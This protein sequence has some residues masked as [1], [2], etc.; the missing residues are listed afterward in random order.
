MVGIHDFFI[1]GVVFLI[2]ASHDDIDVWLETLVAGINRRLIEGI[3]H[4][5]AG[6]DD[7]VGVGDAACVVR[8]QVDDGSG[9]IE[10]DI[11][12]A[13]IL[14]DVVN[15]RIRLGVVLCCPSV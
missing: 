6:I 7:E 11:D 9:I 13:G 5:H 14:R 8:K 10:F 15:G 1:G 12:A 3:I 4:A 2:I